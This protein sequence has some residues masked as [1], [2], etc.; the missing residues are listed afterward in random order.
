MGDRIRSLA[1][2]GKRLIEDEMILM[3]HTE[4][5]GASQSSLSIVDMISSIHGSLD[6]FYT[7]IT[8]DGN[9]IN[10][11]GSHNILVMD[12]G[13]RKI[14]IQRASKV[15]LNHYLIMPGRVARIQRIHR[16]SHVGFYSPLTMSGYLLVNNISTS[17]CVDR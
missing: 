14:E 11:T 12:M 17:L 1:K 10:L 13:T 8:N 6:T 15:T 2:D 5:N 16:S 7:F 3:M 4:R 9:S